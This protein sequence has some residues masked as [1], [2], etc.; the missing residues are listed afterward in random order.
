M[1]YERYPAETIIMKDDFD[2]DDCQKTIEAMPSSSYVDMYTAF[3]TAARKAM[4]E[5]NAKQAKIYWIFSDACSMML[6][7]ENRS[8][9][10]KPLFVFDGRRSAIPD[11]FLEEDIC[12][13]SE[14]IAKITDS[15]LRARLADLAWVKGIKDRFNNALIAIGSYRE[16]SLDPETWVKDGRDCWYRAVS[17]AL[18]LKSGA[19]EKLTEIENEIYKAFDSATLL[20]EYFALNLAEL[21][22]NFRL[23]KSYSESIATKLESFAHQ[24]EETGDLHKARNYFES[25]AKWYDS[26]GN[27][28]KSIEMTIC[29]AEGYA[30]E[31]MMRSAATPPSNI[32]AASFYENAIQILRTVPKAERQNFALDE[33]IAELHKLMNEAGL[34]SRNEMTT[35]TSGSVDITQ[36][37]EMA[38]TSVSGK[39]SEEALKAF[40]SIFSGI[41]LSEMEETALKQ[42]KE[43]PLS[44][45]FT[46]T[47]ISQDGRVVAKTNGIN[48]DEVLTQDHPHVFSSVVQ[49]YNLRLTLI[50]QGSILPAL[51][52]LHLEQRIREVDFFNIVQESP[53]V[54]PGREFLFSKGL[55]AGYG[56][57]FVTALHI[58]VP[59]FEHMVRYHL[60]NAGVRTS[61]VDSCGIENEAG[62]ST[63]VALPEV[64]SVFG[65]DLTFEIRA[66]FCDPF[67]ANLRNELAHGLI[68]HNDCNSV[69]GIYAWWLTLKL[70]FNAFWN[71]ARRKNESAHAG[72]S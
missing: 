47:Y 61:I 7:S 31:A 15:R 4:D 3:S 9:P 25:S 48:F 36:I 52:M 55:F 33:R 16:I 27:K 29:L 34:L 56:Y 5:D 45:L 30:K 53:I 49:N 59:Q 66:L 67:G 62:L 44:S 6:S 38:K 24:L 13:L 46:G 10:F 14:I 42:L 50:V 72:D 21:L 32:L 26:F 64:K 37:V 70:V 54:P 39:N 65:D 68:N 28:A 69:S 18:M 19:R 17:L 63:L 23:G 20:T 8:Q 2:K 43:F 35:I 60:K 41:R 51:E 58:I 12:F 40:A 57:D 71:V 1:S 11:D 22:F